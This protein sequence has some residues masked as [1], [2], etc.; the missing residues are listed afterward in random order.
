MIGLVVL[1]G[2]LCLI[3]TIITT[4]DARTRRYDRRHQRTRWKRPAM[5]MT[6]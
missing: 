5:S 4:L 3:V 6:G 2:G 1:L